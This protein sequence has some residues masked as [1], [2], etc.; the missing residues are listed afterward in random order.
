M[1]SKRPNLVYVFADQLGYQHCGYAGNPQARTPHIDSLA[2]SS[3]NFRQAISPTPVC[4]AYRASLFT[5]K[6]TTSTGMV[7]NEL[8]MNPNHRCIGHV[9]TDAGYETAYLGKWHLWANQ[10]GN[11]DDPKNAFTP[12]GP[13]R[14]G[15]DGTWAAYNFHHEYYGTS[16]YRDEPVAI[17]YGPAGV[18]E[19]DAQVDMAIDL[20]QRH[21]RSN[22]GQPPAQ[23]LAMFLSIGTPHDP[24]RWDNVPEKYAAMFSNVNIPL[25][26]NYS[27]RDDPY[28]DQWG[29]FKACDRAKIPEYLKIYYAMA[30]NLDDNLGR[31]VRALDEAGLSDDT[32]FVFTADH[33]EMF[34]SHG[35]RGK[36]IFFEEAIRVPFLMRCPGT[37]PAGIS[38]V[39]LATPDI[40]P[41]LLGL[42]GLP[43]PAGVEGMDLSHCAR[44]EPGPVPPAALLQNT[45]A[46]ADW[47]D[48][49]EW[50]ALRDAR[51]TYAIFRVDATERLYD[52]L[53]D[54]LQLHNLAD[55]KP[56]GPVLR[57]F[58]EM[59]RAKLAELNDTFAS[60]TWYRDHWTRDRMIV[61][62]ARGASAAITQ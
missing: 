47:I 57:K 40:M 49:H 34:G 56:A 30:A 15:F 28:A 18:Y 1:K 46:C 16:Y 13:Y 37:I 23:P 52:N 51:H 43:I 45:G 2:E 61:S 39:C 12:P 26:A 36:N 42:L 53:A 8:R 41:T 20:L 22:S 44:G 25:P 58:R 54:P 9:L 31:L 60:C 21:G 33:G 14:L 10:L 4:A 32:V 48:G 7:I 29:R 5:G 50:R 19:P 17:P 59:L 27:G 62:A 38:D 3:M 35:R 11:H 55:T 24:W 6:Y